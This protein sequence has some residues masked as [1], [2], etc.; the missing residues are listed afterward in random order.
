MTYPSRAPDGRPVAFHSVRREQ[1]PLTI[2]FYNLEGAVLWEQTLDSAGAVD[3]PG[4][5]EGV[6]A[7]TEVIEA[8]GEARYAVSDWLRRRWDEKAAGED[9]DA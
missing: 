3:I 5:G 9:A 1:L 7:L 6:V 8:T 4:F 2:R